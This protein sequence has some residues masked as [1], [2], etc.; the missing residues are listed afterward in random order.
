MNLIRNSA[1]RLLLGLFAFAAL[2]LP[3]SAQGPQELMNQGMEAYDAGDYETAI[4]KFRQIL[5]ADPSNSEAMELMANSEDAMLQL[6]VAG[7]EWEMFAKEIMEAAAVA[8]REAR[9]DVEAAA[10]DAEGVFSDD[11]S[12]RQQTIFKLASTYGPFAAPPLAKEMASDKESRRLAAIYALSRMGSQLFLP[13]VTCCFSSNAQVRLGALHVLNEMNDPRA[14]P[15]IAS[16]AESDPDG[17]VRALAGQIRVAG[18]PAQMHVKQ[19]KAYMNA[20]MQRGLAPSE[21]YGVLWTTEGAVLSSYEVPSS[22]VALELA[23]FH[24][25]AAEQMGSDAAEPLLARVYAE[26]VA[27]L[28]ADPETAGLAPAQMNALA[29]LPH[30]IVNGALTA[31]LE[32]DDVHGSEVLIEALDAWAGKAWSGLTLGLESGT[33]SVRFAA[34]L[35]LAH[36]RD[37]SPTVVSTLGECLAAQALRVVHIIDADSERAAALASALESEG[38]IVVR[39]SSGAQGIVNM[40]LA[41]VVD[42]FVVSDPAADMYARRFVSQV[43]NGR[44]SEVPVFVYGNEQT[45]ID[46]AEVVDALDAA[47]VVG[48]FAELSTDRAKEASVALRAAHVMVYV[49]LQGNAGPAVDSMAQALSRD[50]D[51]IVV[52]VCAALGYAQDASVVPAL[53]DLLADENRNDEP[54][55]A[56]ARALA[57]LARSANA[58]VD[59]AV[60]QTAMEGAGP[61]LGEACAKLIGA[62]ETGH[63]PAVVEVQ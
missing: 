38:V 10:A 2:A 21:N 31:A 52:W 1:S 24:L 30:S 59:M 35:A 18:D 39:A 60:V 53:L 46:D 11:F 55:A 8:D 32:A 54:R 41:A 26:Q 16:M 51:E 14:E 3:V 15:I 29:S 43:R 57:A 42:A 28:R 19:A 6:L 12:V 61:A 45:A 62:S 4:A 49:A 23:K 13:V 34:A 7:G 25:L 47:T 9:R 44:F 5:A 63:V 50:E 40:N 22:V 48:S 58:T 17:A 20:D 56:A 27:A 37:A 36:T 33:P